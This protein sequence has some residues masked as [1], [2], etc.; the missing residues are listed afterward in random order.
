MRDRYQPGT[1]AQ[2]SATCPGDTGEMIEE[3]MRIGAAVGQ[4]EEMVGNQVTLPPGNPDGVALVVSE[5][6]KP[7]AIIVDQSGAR[8]LNENQSYMSFCQQ[9]LAHDKIVPAVPSWMVLRTAPMCANTWS[10]GPCR[11][12]RSRKPG[13]IRDW[14]KRGETVEQLADRMRDRSREARRDGRAVQRF[15]PSG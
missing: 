13:S 2:W 1:S 4:M 12:R 6:A 11:A 10:P 5:V 7:H 15:C 8:Y 9:M 3:M 14:L